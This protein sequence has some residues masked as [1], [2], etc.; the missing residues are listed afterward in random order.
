MWRKRKAES[1]DSSDDS[2]SSSEEDKKTTKSSKA[3]ALKRRKLL[4]GEQK[5]TKRQF[6]SHED[7]PFK[8]WLN[9]PAQ[10]EYKKKSKKEIEDKWDRFVAGGMQGNMGLTSP[11]S[12]IR[13]PITTKIGLWADWLQAMKR[14]FRGENKTVPL[15]KPMSSE[16]AIRD[17]FHNNGVKS[18]SK[19][20]LSNLK[21]IDGGSAKA[22][23]Q[24]HKANYP[25]EKRLT[26]PEFL[27]WMQDEVDPHLKNSL[28]RQRSRQTKKK[29]K[30]G[31]L[32]GGYKGI[33]RNV[34]KFDINDMP[35]LIDEDSM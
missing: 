11:K 22:L 14:G 13:K 33:G 2:S 23:L 3:R 30:R 12:G 17:F 28:A 25:G 15:R 5:T 4:E 32:S 16:K 10:I 9:Q 20:A 6:G 19:H 27:L 26:K 24:W 29:A 18:I 1:S 7:G 31:P 34:P 35:G 8:Q 21:E